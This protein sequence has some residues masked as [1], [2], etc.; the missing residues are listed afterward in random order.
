MQSAETRE[1]PDNTYQPKAIDTTFIRN[2]TWSMVGVAANVF[3]GVVLSPYIIRLLGA[4]RFGIWALVFAILDYLWLFDLGLTPAI[5]NLITRYLALRQLVK[6]NEVINTATCYFLVLASLLWV[7]TAFGSSRLVRLFNVSAAYRSEFSGLIVMTGMSWGLCVVL[8]MY[9]AALDA[10][11]RFDLTNKV[12]LLVVVGRSAGYLVT[13]MAGG[14]LLEIGAVYVLSQVIGSLLHARNFISVFPSLRLSPRF[15]RGQVF[16]DILRYG[17]PAFFANGST[18]IL[19]QSAPMLIG[20]FLSSSFVGFFA[21]P[22]KLVQNVTDVVSRIALVT[23]S[24]VAELDATADQVGIVELAIQVNRYCFAVFMPFL[25][26]FALFGRELIRLWL[27]PQF[28]AHAA[29]LIVPLMASSAFVFGGQFNS[30]AVL[31]GLGRHRGYARVLTC[32]SALAVLG[33]YV[34]VPRFGILGAAY[35]V[36][37]LMVGFRGLLTPLLLCR[38]LNYSFSRYIT[39]IYLRPA[40]AAVAVGSLIAMLRG[41]GLRGLNWWQLAVIGVTTASLY[42]LSVVFIC[43]VPIH[44]RFVIARV[45]GAVKRLNLWV[46]SCHS[47]GVE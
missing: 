37:G 35:L 21:L 20:H 9:T 8:Q 24:R 1:R 6:I 44:R 3:V 12:N 2:S 4:E 14:G 45:I 18:L 31:F 25:I 28:V 43:L 47:A 42:G 38:S 10:F 23:R 33:L 22:A 39:R 40:A 30:A 17:I 7:L 11:Q 5:A 19:N 34:V 15:V 26:F 36:A 16:R 29:P 13:L 27:G 32:E 41:L 46:T